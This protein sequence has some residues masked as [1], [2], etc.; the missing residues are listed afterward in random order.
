MEEIVV[1]A[2]VM[3]PDQDSVIATMDEGEGQPEICEMGEATESTITETETQKVVGTVTDTEVFLEAKDEKIENEVKAESIE[4]EPKP[5][6]VE[7]NEVEIEAETPEPSEPT[8]VT[9]TEQDEDDDIICLNS[10]DD[11]DANLSGASDS[12]R[13]KK[14]ENELEMETDEK[15]A[16][17]GTVAK[18]IR[19]MSRQDLEDLV[20]AKIVEAVV[21]HTEVGH[22]R[23]RVL[24]LQMQKDKMASK[25]GVMLKQVAELSTAVNFITDNES[26]DGKGR[27]N[28]PHVIRFNRSVGLQTSIEPSVRSAPPKI[29]RV[30]EPTQNG[31]KQYGASTGKT[32]IYAGAANGNFN[33]PQPQPHGV[34]RVYQGNRAGEAK[35]IVSQN[36]PSPRK[37]YS[38]AS[39]PP[40][41]LPIA[42]KPVNIIPTLPSSITVSTTQSQPGIVDLTDDDPPSLGAQNVTA[43]ITA[44]SAGSTN[45]YNGA[46]QY[47]LVK[48]SASG[49]GM[50]I[51]TPTA[52]TPTKYIVTGSGQNRPVLLQ[53]VSVGT[54]LQPQLAGNQQIV[55]RGVNNLNNTSPLTI[56]QRPAAP[57]QQSDLSAN[58]T[59]SRVAATIPSRSGTVLSANSN[60]QQRRFILPPLPTTPPPKTKPNEMYRSPP[61]PELTLNEQAD[62]IVL[63]WNLPT[64]PNMAEVITYQIF[65]CQESLSG[66]SNRTS[67][68]KRVGDVKALPLPMACT[69]SQF[70]EENRYYFIVRGIDAYGRVGPFCDPQNILLK[71]RNK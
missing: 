69:L 32:T 21:A 20:V 53:Q 31:V 59:V 68:W 8:V 15:G 56:I 38:P 13:L 58:I 47:Q 23:S 35:Q 22:L 50:Q 44:T 45:F 24:D 11:D 34:K 2:A 48:S 29:I 71:K 4:T 18:V 61:K 64:V 46:V 9:I 37:V 3:L 30:P 16:V 52:T 49:Q 1:E 5:E 70:T 67:H 33:P 42:P 57:R 7:S 63:S 62:G 54:G 51:M 19:R 28:K 55:L 25:F 36:A 27:P 10:D 17:S 65:A 43:S 66:S 26:R 39:G 6:T 14:E 41:M 60:T 12:K 40:R